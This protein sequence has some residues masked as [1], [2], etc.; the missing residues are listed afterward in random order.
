MAHA[1]RPPENGGGSV[2]VTQMIE[3][4][5]HRANQ[6]ASQMEAQAANFN[7]HR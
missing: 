5:S 4:L 2:K 6:V 7:Q 1:N 3:R